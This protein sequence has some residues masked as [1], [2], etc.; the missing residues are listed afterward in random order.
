MSGA[1]L[2]RFILLL[3]AAGSL[4]TVIKLVRTGLSQRY[5]FFTLLFLLRVPE[6]L[7]PVF[8]NPRS[9]TYAYMYV[10]TEPLFRILYVLVVLELY[11]LILDQYKGLYSLGRW[12]MYGSSALAAMISILTLLPH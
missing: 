7:L 8:L 11:K 3:T 1:A 12:V 9:D 5:R 10:A 4:L 6:L 2:V